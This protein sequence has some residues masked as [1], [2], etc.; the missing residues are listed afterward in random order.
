VPSLVSPVTRFLET[1]SHG[2]GSPVSHRTRRETKL[3][4][5]CQA[6][7]RWMI[8]SGFAR[9]FSPMLEHTGAFLIPSSIFLTCLE[10]AV[11]CGS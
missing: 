4:H 9:Y 6:P 10:T 8:G 5:V 2:C 11:T 1:R 7:T 3:R